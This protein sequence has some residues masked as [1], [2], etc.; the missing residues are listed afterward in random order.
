MLLDMPSPQPIASAAPPVR[1]DSLPESA[2]LLLDIARF[3]LAVLVVIGHVSQPPSSV[4][5]PL[6]MAGADFAVPAF[7]VLSGFV[8][9]YVTLTRERDAKRY[10]VNR[11]S[12]MYSVVLPAIAV[13]FVCALFTARMNPAFWELAAGPGLWDHLG[14][15]LFLAL[16]FLTQFW[17]HNVILLSDGPLWSLGYEVPYYVLFGVLTFTRGPKRWLLFGAV[18]LC[19]GPQIAYLLPL[20][21]SGCWLYDLWQATR[22]SMQAVWVSAGC[23]VAALLLILPWPLGGM[24]RIASLPNPIVVFL[25]QDPRRATN[26][27]WAGGLLAFALLYVALIIS[28]WIPLRGGAAWARWVRRIAE[29]TF[30]LYVL[31]RP[32]LL[33]AGALHLYRTDHTLDKVLLIF[34]LTVI[35]IL[36]ASP[37]DALKNVLRNLLTGKPARV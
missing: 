22:K 1:K 26:L 3:S 11:I 21:W 29:G 28:D 27:A 30:A 37:M 10:W 19:Y 32:L 34:V 12:R 16:T 20:W 8:I 7:F 23:M 4:G 36:A 9:R 5:W 31:H 6:L 2:S 17:S 35:G 15:R 33:L 18:L 14:V 24:G 13:T 25:H